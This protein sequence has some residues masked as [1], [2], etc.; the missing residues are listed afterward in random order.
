MTPVG[1]G[2]DKFTAPDLDKVA[3]GK[4]WKVHN[5]VPESL[6]IDGKRAVRLKARGDSADRMAGWALA[7]GVEFGT[8][9]I[10]IEL[11]GKNV[12]QESFLGIAFNV[13]DEKTF[14]AVYFR[15]FNFK[16]DGDFKRRAVQYIAWPDNTWNKLR[17]DKPGKFEGPISPVPDP[18]GWFRVRVEVVE[19]QVHVFVNNV[20][21]PC[22]TVDDWPKAAR[23]AQLGCS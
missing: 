2:Q 1:N 13:V 7:S 9:T 16:A 3:D 17:K 22:L 5:A 15:P 19:K 18:D 14:E 20:K 23:A 21:E 4:N 6:E 8:G 12:K 10:E 11:K